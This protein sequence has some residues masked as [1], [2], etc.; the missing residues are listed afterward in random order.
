MLRFSCSHCK[1]T[2]LRPQED[3]GKQL[4]CPRC[5][6]KVQVPA[7]PRSE[8]EEPLR[9]LDDEEPEQDE[10]PAEE[11]PP[12]ELLRLL[13]DFNARLDELHVDFAEKPDDDL[14][15]GEDEQE[16]LPE[17][18]VKELGKK[19]R[20]YRP[21]SGGSVLLLV[22]SGLFFVG[23]AVFLGLAIA[24]RAPILLLGA[25]AA[26]L[27][28]GLLF[29]KG[30]SLLSFRIS[31]Y[32]GGWVHSRFGRKRLLAW[33]DANSVR[34]ETI[35]YYVNGVYSS[36]THVTTVLLRD[37][38]RLICDNTIYDVRK[39]GESLFWEIN[40]AN[41]PRAYHAL[42]AGYKV[43][44]ADLAVSS[45]GIHLEGKLL[46]WEDYDTVAIYSGI[47]YVRK[48]RKRRPWGKAPVPQIPNVLV[49]LAL[50]ETARKMAKR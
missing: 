1:Q 37:G 13:P 34:Q 18:R 20:T 15:F 47:V 14:F 27:T 32:Q 45:K 42:E 31:V 35:V 6:K 29:W 5:H 38:T 8:E 23:I 33:R 50:V 26:A 10:E 36:T 48:L 17:R 3:A 28:G 49:F 24:F 7:G 21:E 19:Q 40:R 4:S 44:F 43:Y 12:D 25:L 2:I 41:F 11:G 46:R 39:L 9:V 22:L 16:E 30:W